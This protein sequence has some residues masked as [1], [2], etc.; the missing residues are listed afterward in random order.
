MV[1]GH[2][3]IFEASQNSQNGSSALAYC[4]V[5]LKELCFALRLTVSEIMAIKVLIVAAILDFLKH[6]KTV[7]MAFGQ[8]LIV[9]WGCR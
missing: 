1:I 5:G 2:L 3:G 4:P 8:L 9:P 7:K 6:L